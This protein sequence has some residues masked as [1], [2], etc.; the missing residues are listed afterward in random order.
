M[1]D[2]IKAIGSVKTINLAGIDRVRERI[3]EIEKRFGIAGDNSFQATLEREMRKARQADHARATTP[4]KKSADAVERATDAVGAAND[5]AT[6]SVA[7]T[8]NIAS[9]E[10]ITF[11]PPTEQREAELVDE[12]ADLEKTLTGDPELQQTAPASNGASIL[13]PPTEQLP[14]EEALDPF[15]AI[16]PVEN[17]TP[18]PETIREPIVETVVE[19]AMISVPSTTEEIIEAAASK[20]NVDAN[21][22]K[23]IATAESD[24]DQ[25][26]RSS[27]GAIGVMQLMPET[28]DALGVNPYDIEENIEGGAKY[29]RQMLDTFDGNV[30]NAIAAYNAGPGAVK[31]YGGVPPY[32]ETQNYVGRVLDLYE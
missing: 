3:A 29:I 27:V 17:P 4:T 23:A 10:P 19:G 5:V 24:W 18:T 12:F 26:A 7:P 28:A 21:L 8:K 22:V 9:T 25:S 14:G 11:T 15:A 1:I 30:R 2:P 6:S 20:Y 31:R 13:N 32:A 16:T